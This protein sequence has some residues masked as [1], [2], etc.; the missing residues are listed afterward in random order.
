MTEVIALKPFKDGGEKRAPRDKF[1]VHPLRAKELAAKG[2][3][4]IATE[5]G[6][7]IK[8]PMAAGPAAPSSSSAAAPPSVP[9]ILPASKSGAKRVRNRKKKDRGAS[10]SQTPPTE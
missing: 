1:T 4:R 3:V 8:K 10:S 7:P 6:T 5:A 2:L 9:E